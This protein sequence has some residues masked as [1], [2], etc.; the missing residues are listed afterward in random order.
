MDAITPKKAR[1]SRWSRDPKLDER[2]RQL[3]AR[4]TDDDIAAL[5]LLGR[6][7]YLPIDY[8]AALDSRALISLQWRFDL[9]QRKPNQYVNRPEQQRENADANYRRLIYE[10]D[11]KGAAELAKRGIQ[12]SRKK[13]HR[14]FAHELMVCLIAASFEIGTRERPEIQIIPW[15]D[16]LA[17]DKLPGRTRDLSEPRAIPFA[18]KKGETEIVL[19]DWEPFVLKTASGFVFLPGF[20]ADCGTEPIDATDDTRS[21]IRAKFV[22]YLSVMEQETYRSHFGASTFMVPFITNS[23]VRMQSMMALLERMQPGKY[24]SRFIFKHIP[25]FTAREV[26]P[27]TGHMLTQP[28]HRIGS[29]FSFVQ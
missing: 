21:S 12:Y 27:A 8:I 11:D 14:N 4:I 20:E 10:L 22:A 25:G 6:Y 23:E 29:P 26:A 3:V 2:G 16:I 7:R 1:N 5:T 18:G 13:Y 24:G 28:W 17:S 9:L 15:R 19:A